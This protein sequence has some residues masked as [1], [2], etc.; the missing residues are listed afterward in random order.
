MSESYFILTLD[1]TSPEVE[2]YM[3]SYTT[4]YII[5]EIR[6]V[7]NEPL[8]LHSEIYIIDSV[9]KRH[10]LT[11]RLKGNEYIGLVQFDGYPLGISTLY[12][13]VY[14]IG[15]NKSPLVSKSFQ[16][17]KSEEINLQTSDNI[18]NVSSI[19]ISEVDL[20]LGEDYMRTKSEEK[21]EASIR[22]SESIQSIET[23]EVTQKVNSIDEVVKYG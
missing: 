21:E 3:P 4:R 15:W 12:A 10:D 16:I 18:Q 6:V 1:T 13:Q 8:S 19:D 17:I 9:G 5:D 7:A 11:F 14:D 20:L 23:E 2:I 22:I